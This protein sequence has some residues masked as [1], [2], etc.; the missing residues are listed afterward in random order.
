MAR[1]IDKELTDMIDEFN[2]N[3]AE[4]FDKIEATLEKLKAAIRGEKVED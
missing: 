1:Q 2:A 3:M 4:K